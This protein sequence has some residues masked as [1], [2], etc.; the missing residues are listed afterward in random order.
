MEKKGFGAGFIEM[1]K[2]KVDIIQIIDERIRLERRG[3][4][5]W[6]CCPFHHEKTPSFNVNEYEQYYHCFGCGESG[7]V[8]TFLRKYENW[9]YLETVK[10]LAERAGVPLPKLD[11]SENYIKQKKERDT[12]IQI[13]NLA[14]EIYKQNIYEPQAV[15]AQNYLKKRKVGRRE[16]ENFEIGYSVSSFQVA[17]ILKQKGFSNQDLKNAGLCEIGKSGVA[18]DL[19]SERLMFP[20]VNSYGDCIGFSGRDLTGTSHAKY[21]NSP[22][23]AVFDKSKT[24]YAINLIKNLRR[25]ESVN[26]IIIVEGQFDVITMHHNGFRNTVACMGTAFT[27]E[28]IRELR[29]FTNQII[30][31]LDGDEAGRKATLRTLDVLRD[32]EL[33][34]KVCVLPDGMDPDEFL[35][36]YGSEKLRELLNN[37]MTPID[38]KL[39]LAKKRHNLST[40]E[41][42]SAF[43]KEA[44]EFVSEL[45]S[46]SEQEIYLQEVQK[47]TGVSSEILRR[48]IKT[49]KIQETSPT[50]PDEKPKPSIQDGSVKAMQFVLACMLHKKPYTQNLPDLTE[51]IVNPTLTKLYEIIMSF[52][53]E[54]K[55]IIVSS[56]FDHFDMENENILKDIVNMNFEII[57]DEE[58]YFKSCLWQIIESELKFRKGELSKQYKEEIDSAKKKQLLLDIAKI[59]LQL[60]NKNLGDF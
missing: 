3:K 7:D 37:A 49:T 25:E 2:S 16:L 23:S 55:E 22:A 38:F 56:V 53:R 34:V 18:Y 14:R 24:V 52:R 12:S 13:L 20:I 59:D 30:L 17:D 48:D 32:S 1:L 11:Q 47:I 45:P 44:I 15:L 40:N 28:H 36:T 5:Y 58:K 43:L 50:T 60:K 42:K 19:L 27:K 39:F 29:R 26:N 33:G 8:I 21:K 54:G 4:A 57:E 51:F 6:A 31:C 41:G 46:S 10:Y 35:S 9:S